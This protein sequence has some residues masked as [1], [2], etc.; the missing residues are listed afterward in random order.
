MSSQTKSSQLK[1]DE[2]ASCLHAKDK[3]WFKVGAVFFKSPG[4]EG[5]HEYVDE[6]SPDKL[7]GHTNWMA[8]SHYVSFSSQRAPCSGI[9]IRAWNPSIPKPAFLPVHRCPN[10]SCKFHDIHRPLS[11]TLAFRRLLKP[12]RILQS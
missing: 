8:F 12:R 4:A 5:H 10:C 3:S 1:F 2:Q 7:Q 9:G 11:S 6:K